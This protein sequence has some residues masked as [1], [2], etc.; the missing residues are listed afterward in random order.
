MDG[1]ENIVRSEYPNAVA[2]FRLGSPQTD[3]IV[4]RRGHWAVIAPSAFV[5]DP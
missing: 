1:C 5:F 4:P 3:S 2:E